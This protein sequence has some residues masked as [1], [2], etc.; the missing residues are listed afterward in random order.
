MD[1]SFGKI[2]LFLSVQIKLNRFNIR[3][4][5]YNVNNKSA[6]KIELKA[7]FFSTQ[8]LR[9][10]PDFA[11]TAMIYQLK[12]SHCYADSMNNKWTN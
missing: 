4:I 9:I 11:K 6:I 10:M 5:C 12:I 7:L 2:N 1:Q 8:K 3:N